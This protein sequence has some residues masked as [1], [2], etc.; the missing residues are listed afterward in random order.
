MVAVVCG[1]TAPV[2]STAAMLWTLES[3]RKKL[4]DRLLGSLVTATGVPFSSVTFTTTETFWITPVSVVLLIF[5]VA[6]NAWRSSVSDCK[7]CILTW[8]QTV[9]CAWA[10][11]ETNPAKPSNSKK[12]R[13]RSIVNTTACDS[14]RPKKA[15]LTKPPLQ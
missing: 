15:R 3:L 10:G 11:N 4:A 6:S 2:P 8:A 14:S 12:I 7:I 1:W 9:S 5:I 13:L